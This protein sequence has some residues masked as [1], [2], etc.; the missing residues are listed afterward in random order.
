VDYKIFSKC[1]AER[2]KRVLESVIHHFGFVKGRN[3]S[4]GIRAIL[5]ILDETD[6]KSTY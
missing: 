1:I 2:I 4:D 3:I 6:K 5:E